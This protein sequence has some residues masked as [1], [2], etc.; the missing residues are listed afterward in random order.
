MDGS[1]LHGTLQREGVT[2]AGV[3]MGGAKGIT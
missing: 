1:Q 3:G 2:K